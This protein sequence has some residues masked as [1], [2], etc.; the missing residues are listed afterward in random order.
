V[1]TVGST[2]LEPPEPVPVVLPVPVPTL[3]PVPV[4]TVLPVPVPV[5]APLPDPVGVRWL[6]MDPSHPARSATP[7]INV[8]VQVFMRSPRPGKFR[9]EIDAKQSPVGTRAEKCRRRCSSKRS[10]ISS[11]TTNVSEGFT[12]V[13]RALTCRSHA[14]AR[15]FVSVVP[16]IA[17]LRNTSAFPV[18]D[19]AISA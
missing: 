3:L 14:S 8:L 9:R 16:T 7:T 15:R 12:L 19:H 4:P 13:V 5:L 10:S 11:Q 6:P 18:M 1:Q 17:V 2:T